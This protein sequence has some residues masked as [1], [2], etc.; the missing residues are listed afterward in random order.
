MSLPTDRLAP[1][2]LP[3]D[4]PIFR[5]P[6]EARVFALAVCLSRSGL[7]TWSEWTEALVARTK[8][9]DCGAATYDVWLDTLEGLLITK[10]AANRALI[11]MLRDAWRTTAEATPHGR[12]VVLA[13]GVLA[14]L[15]PSGSDT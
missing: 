7:F 2:G 9:S 8:T 12:P 11:D 13:P 14:A 1:N 15:V 5:E 3:P 6:W 4:G 10:G